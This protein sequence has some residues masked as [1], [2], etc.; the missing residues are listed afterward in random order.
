M[1]EPVL[2]CGAG[3]TG[4]T[5]ALELARFGV[6]FRLIDRAAEPVRHAPALAVH[7]RT[8]EVLEA[9]GVTASLL[10]HVHRIDGMSVRDAA[11]ALVEV[12]FA[13]MP[14]AYDYVAIVPQQTT[15]RLFS[16]RL[17]AMGCTLERGV[18]LRA[19]LVDDDGANATLQREGVARTERFSY[20]AACD[21]A[22]GTI[23][24]LRGLAPAGG[25]PR[26]SFMLADLVLATELD[27]R[28]I[29]I[30][31]RDDGCVLA[32]IPIDGERWRLICE[33]SPDTPA[34]PAL[35]DFRAALEAFGLAKTVEARDAEWTARYAVERR[36]LAH[37]RDTRVFFLGD[38][39]H[40]HSPVG[41]Q[42]MNA[43]IQDAVNLA[44]KLALVLL[45]GADPRLLDTYAEEREPVGRALL[46]A[47]DF[48]KRFALAAN[49]L[50]RSLRATVAPVA[51]RLDVVHERLR[52]GV[53]GLRIAYPRS[54]LSVH[55]RAPRGGT[56]AGA[57]LRG[58][59][60][61]THRPQV[62]IGTGEG[63]RETTIVV[64]PDGHAGYVAAGAQPTG[65]E[66]YLRNIIGLG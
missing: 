18:T 28:R 15:E 9:S 53:S 7:A 2:I 36:K 58:S 20:V 41:G 47:A 52:E 55:G 19:L 56:V 44:W 35:A 66:L 3:P 13:G 43:G 49:P 6:P 61:A 42:G 14:T 30:F 26:E 39:A 64:R 4:L 33:S 21:G 60:P 1:A 17:A 59:R 62:L 51:A 24:R 22:H 10:E 45:E 31:L 8:L 54:S 23:G 50:A 46:G 57:R 34:D 11:R 27:P 29:A 32:C 12:E 25:T 48:G 38:A 16:E 5:L 37:Y 63:E 40:V 65:A